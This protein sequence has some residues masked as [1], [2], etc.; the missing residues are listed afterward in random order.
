VYDTT[1]GNVGLPSNYKKTAEIILQ[2]TDG[3]HVRTVRLIG[4]WP[5]ALNPGALDMSS[6]APVEIEAT[7][8]YD[9]AEW[10]L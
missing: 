5:S 9:R 3:T 6:D 8:T 7:L 10:L 4:I 2:A 1:T